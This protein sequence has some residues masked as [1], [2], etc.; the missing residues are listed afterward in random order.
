[1]NKQEKTFEYYTGDEW[2]KIKEEYIFND[3][4]LEDIEI[5]HLLE[6][7]KNAAREEGNLIKQTIREEIKNL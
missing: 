3:E 7:G 5:H 2:L 6:F 1:M 4:P